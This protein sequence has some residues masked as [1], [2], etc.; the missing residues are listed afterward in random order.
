M[1]TSTRQ[2]DP[3]SEATAPL[4]FSRVGGPLVAIVGLAGGAG[5]STLAHLLSAAAAAASAATATPVLL[6]ETGGPRASLS[7]LAGVSSRCSLADVARDIDAGRP[8]NGPLFAVGDDGLRVIAAGPCFEPCPASDTSLR[9]VLDD[10]RAAHGLTVV[11]CCSPDSAVDHAMLAMATH[12]VW[13]AAATTSASAQATAALDAVDLPIRGRELL[14]VRQDEAD[15]PSA[16]P[17]AW[18]EIA[19][20]RDADVVLLPWVPRLAADPLP[21]RID[22]VLLSLQALAGALR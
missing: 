13:L 10:A 4:V 1:E 20:R 18:S 9:L 14:A 11:D 6:A 8:S 19:R 17:H 15:L 12:V 21:A 3:L 22:R 5:A 16:T 2:S 7:L